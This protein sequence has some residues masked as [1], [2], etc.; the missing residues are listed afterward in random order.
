MFFSI[1][2][3]RVRMQAQR[4]FDQTFGTAYEGE[5]FLCGGA[6]K[7]L[8]K[9]GL[10]VNDFDLWVRDR[11]ERERLTKFLLSRGAH[12]M[13]DFHPYC[14]KLRLDG[15]IIEITYHNVNDGAL[16]DVVNTFDLSICGLG[17]CYRNGRVVES[18]VSE[19]C[20][21]AVRRRSVQV[22]PSYFCLL[23]LTHASSIIRTLHR[24]GQST[25]R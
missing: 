13:R 2:K 15:R 4:L 19:E 9:R 17:A 14:L 12:L 20:W 3:A 1:F 25:L 10:P 8:L 6:F 24:M 22:L 5:V 23:N 21:Q 7:P 18:F 16:R 11:Q